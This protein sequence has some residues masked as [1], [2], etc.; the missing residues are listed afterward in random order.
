M[1]NED[2]EPI[3]PC[4]Q[5]GKGAEKVHIS[6]NGR[7]YHWE[8]PQCEYEFGYTEEVPSLGEEDW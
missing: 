8:C 2:G 3:N 5:C 6:M 4:P 1:H 7:I